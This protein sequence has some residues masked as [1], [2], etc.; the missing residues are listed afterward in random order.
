MPSL[1]QVAA[2]VAAAGV[3]AGGG[4][5]AADAAI[6]P[7]T[8]VNVIQ[9][10]VSV[11]ALAIAASS[12]IPDAGTVQT[13]IET[14]QPE[15][16]L[17]KWSGQVNMGVTYEG[18]PA[19]TTG[20]RPFMSQDVDWNGASQSMQEVPL[21]ASTTMEDGGYEIN[22]I[23]NSEPA[24]NTF[25]FAISAADNLDF[26]YQ[27][28]LWQ[29]AGLTAPTSTCTDTQCSLPDGFDADRPAN[30]VGSYAVYYANHAN[31]VEGQTNY[32]TG[33]A[34]QI[35][36]PQV[37]DSTGS[38]TW[39]TLSYATG[40]LSVIVP[41]EF[42]DT[43][44]YP[45]TIDPTIGYTTIGAS[46]ETQTGAFQYGNNYNNTTDS[47][48]GPVTSVSY[49]AKC[50]STS[51]LSA[52][53]VYDGSSNLLS[54][55]SATTNMTSTAGWITVSFSGPTLSANT[56]YQTAMQGTGASG[57]GCGPYYDN[58]G[59]SGDGK[60]QFGITV[61]TWPNPATWTS[62]IDRFSIY[63]T[64]TDAAGPAATFAP[65]QFNDF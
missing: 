60:Q 44:T 58:T 35:F 31:Y 61:G 13:T 56:V 39:A 30:V 28:P 1:S 57:D 53:A 36:R 37:T 23:L 48:G 2:G 33:K 19:T 20:A 12:T 64:Y 25:P 29:E 27:P 26:F 16:V 24:T 10:G 55:Q 47:H 43:A 5:L 40:T 3:I 7:Y 49:Y 34:Y 22:I 9:N 8:S 46:N 4:S 32:A 54:P 63:T 65:W 51:H 50:A 62:N 38:T 59:N 45:V 42:L 15:V 18:L 21:A 17:S 11:P 14:T 41:Q 6:N 52:G